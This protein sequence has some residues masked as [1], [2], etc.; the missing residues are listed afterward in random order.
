M[1]MIVCFPSLPS[2][3]PFL[4][5]AP[6]AY[7]N[8]PLYLLDFFVNIAMIYA[9]IDP[10]VAVL[11]Q[12]RLFRMLKLPNLL[13]YVSDS[14]T[15]RLFFTMMF[16]AIPS[17]NSV[18]VMALSTIFF[19][20]VI[21]VQLYTG[22]SKRCNSDLFPGARNFFE[23][24]P[25]NFPTGCF[26]FGYDN[27]NVNFTFITEY[28]QTTG[29]PIYNN[30]SG[31]SVLITNLHVHATLDNFLSILTG[32]KSMLRVIFNNEWQVNVYG[33]VCVRI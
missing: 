7:F 8:Q 16:E 10:N 30:A 3:L 29:A 19:T 18:F 5:G 20:A 9:Y 27:T 31:Y 1:M 24:D 13:L 17:L 22:N 26:G 12:L 28:N 11:N 14:N 4:S 21:G 25:V 6:D 2:F 15:L 33:Y 32:C 23:T